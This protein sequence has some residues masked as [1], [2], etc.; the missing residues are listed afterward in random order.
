MDFKQSKLTKTEWES[1]EK[2]VDSKENSILKMIRDGLIQPNSDCRLYFTTNQMLKLEHP[3]KDYHIYMVLFKDVLK[4]Y[5]LETM[6]LP[7]PKKP[8]NSADTIRLKSMTT[9]ID[10][11][12]EIVLLDLVRK[13]NKSKKSKELYYYNIQYLSEMYPINQWIKKWIQTFLEKNKSEVKVIRFLENTY[14]YLENN[15]IFRYKPLQL[16]EHQKSVYEIMNQPGPKMIGYRAPTSSGKTLTPLGISQ[17]YKVIFVCASRHIGISL[18]K[19]AVNANVKVGF[20]FGCSTS[21]DVRLH[22]SSVRTF[23]EK[24]GKKRPVHSDGRNVDL[25][26]CDIQSYEVAML[27]MLSFFDPQ[28]MVLFWDEPTI[29]MDYETHDLHECISKVWEVNTIPNIVLSSATLPNQEDLTEMFDKYKEKYKGEVFYVESMDETTHITLLDSTGKIVT[30][31]QVF[32]LDRAGAMTFIEKHG[33][34]HMKF[35]SLSECAEFILYFS[36]KYTTVK[37][38][39]SDTFPTLASINS[40]QLRMFYY[41]VMQYLPEWTDDIQTYLLRRPPS[42]MNVSNLV[43]TESSHTLTHGPTIYLCENTQDWIEFFVKNSGI[44]PN[45]LMEMEK[46]L[47]INQDILEKINKV[48]KDIEDKTAKDEGNENKMK[49]QRFDP[50]T[51]T[52]IQEMECLERSLK[53]VHL[54]PTYIPNTREHFDKWTTDMNFATANAF[55]SDIDESYVRKIMKLDVDI[56]YKILILM[57]VGVFHPQASDYSDIMKDLSEQKKLGVILA[58]SDF[59]YGT[60]YQFC[61]AYIAEDLCKMTQEKI[62]Q[63]IG[64]VGRKEQ[65]KTFTFR[66]REDRLIHSLFIQENTL[67]TKQMNRLFI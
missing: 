60:N 56:S 59:I 32:A 5:E 6:D 13:F 19:S 67:E 41:K 3:D 15:E 28:S 44:H 22:Y 17:R 51:K 20:S 46:K 29:T 57:G 43:V 4:K 47:Q 34:S 65:N 8:L 37:G 53:P 49:E 66:F 2:K 52:M 45:T 62:I 10:E 55:R 31:H 54:H 23:T 36:K 24:Y 58:S 27:Y 12:V 30:P 40:Q 25:M 35:L 9:K 16:Y 21:D 63:A 39:L 11:S 61:H 33:M 48:R 38:W 64:R 7:K 42:L 26:I 50:A 18:A 1:M 14:K